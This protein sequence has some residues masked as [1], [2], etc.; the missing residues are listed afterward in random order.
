MLKRTL[1]A[2]F[3]AAQIALVGALAGF[4]VAGNATI[5]QGSYPQCFPDECCWDDS[6]ED[7]DED[8]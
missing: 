3:F 7:E 8:E 2:A 4:N 6:C 5:E 1:I